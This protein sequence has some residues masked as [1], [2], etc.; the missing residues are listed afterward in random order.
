MEDLEYT[1]TQSKSWGKQITSGGWTSPNELQESVQMLLQ[2]QIAQSDIGIEVIENTQQIVVSC[3]SQQYSF[4]N[5]EDAESF[6]TRLDGIRQRMK[7]MGVAQPKPAK[8][9]QPW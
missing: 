9:E 5:R 6:V 8:N 7:G 2:N 1:P 3:G 4:T